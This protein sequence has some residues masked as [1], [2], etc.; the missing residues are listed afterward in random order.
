MQPFTE[1]TSAR[2][3]SVTCKR[4]WIE[5]DDGQ[6]AML[7]SADDEGGFLSV[8]AKGKDHTDYRRTV[9]LSISETG[10]EIILNGTQG[11]V[12]IKAGDGI[13]VTGADG[14]IVGSLHHHDHAEGHD[15][16]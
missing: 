12:T 5:R 13:R 8:Y 16:E 7:L 4:L 14:R 15:A 6:T 11:M 2:I 3:S 9:W 10:G 1:Q